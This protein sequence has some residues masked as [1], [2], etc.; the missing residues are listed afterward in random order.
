MIDLKAL[1]NV[2]PGVK[3]ISI[4]EHA[5]I[6]DAKVLQV[7]KDDGIMLT[8]RLENKHRVGDATLYSMVHDMIDADDILTKGFI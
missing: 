7:T 2:V 3:H 5:V 4:A 8:R 1:A 6:A